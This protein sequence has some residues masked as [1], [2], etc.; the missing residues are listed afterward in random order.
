MTVWVV[1]RRQCVKKQIYQLL[2]LRYWSLDITIFSEQV[3]NKL[4]RIQNNVAR[5]VT[6]STRR[7][8]AQDLLDS[9]HWLPVRE[10]GTFKMATMIYTVSFCGEPSVH[11]TW[12]HWFRSTLPPA[13]YAHQMTLLNSWSLGFILHWLEEVS[14]ELASPQRPPENISTKL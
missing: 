1:L 7:T 8:H 5:I 4:Q 12:L 14:L 13:R 10:R 3:F 11:H 6:N 2:S 9:L